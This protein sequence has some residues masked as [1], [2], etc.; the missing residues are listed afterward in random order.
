[1]NNISFL[2]NIL[3]G[4]GPKK[5]EQFRPDLMPQVTQPIPATPPPIAAEQVPLGTVADLSLRRPDLPPIGQPKILRPEYTDAEGPVEG[6]GQTPSYMRG[7]LGQE[8]SKDLGIAQYDKPITGYEA[9]PQLEGLFG[10]EAVGGLGYELTPQPESTTGPDTISRTVGTSDMAPPG[11]PAAAMPTIGRDPLA[12]KDYSIVKDEAGNVIHRGADRDKKWSTWDKIASGIV[13]WA[14]GGLAGGIKAATDRNFFEKMGDQ[15]TRARL[16]P[17]IAANQKI[18][19]GEAV[20]G[21]KRAQPILAAAEI[22]R[23]I[24]ADAK[25]DANRTK[26]FNLEAQKVKDARQRYKVTVDNNG[27]RWKE[28][29]QKDPDNPTRP[30][31]EPF[32]DPMTGKQEIDSIGKVHQ[33]RDPE[34]GLM[35]SLNSKDVAQFGFQRAMFNARQTQGSSEFNAQRQLDVDKTNA[36]NEMKYQDDVR[37][38]IT[39]IAAANANLIG[40]NAEAQTANLRVQAAREALEA[41][42]GKDAIEKA[43]KEFDGAVADFGKALGKGQGGAAL[44]AELQKAMPKRPT[45]LTYTPIQAATVGGNKVAGQT[46]LERFAQTKGWDIETARKYVQTKGWDI[47]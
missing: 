43:R 28:Y 17:Q 31:K 44:A 12:L 22:E 15:N 10:R 3:G 42:S 32:F 37:A 34:T 29:L 2:Q 9:N 16:L 26:Q 1:M 14:Q 41:A 45:R 46:D 25:L 4:L 27:L 36:A 5:E 20:I 23:K 11:T 38:V 19:E 13:G 7:L 18:A 33:Y 40:G 8:A 6:Q 47:R 35:L 21:Q 39:Q 30:D 24:A